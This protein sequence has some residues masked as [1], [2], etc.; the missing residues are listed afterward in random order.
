MLI[1]LGNIGLAILPVLA[2]LLLFH[3]TGP[4]LSW[5]KL[6]K[7]LL[8]GY[9]IVIPAF[10]IE[11]GL[12][13]LLERDSVHLPEMARL[14]LYSFVIAAIT[15]EFFKLLIIR[16]IRSKND[17]AR[18]M[19]VASFMA[20][21]GFALFENLKYIFGP[22]SILLLR[23]ITA[24]PLHGICAAFIGYSFAIK[25]EKKRSAPVAGFLIAVIF[26]G[27]YDL[28]LM[29]ETVYSYIVL[30]LLLIMYAII[31][32]LYSLSV[33]RRDYFR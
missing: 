17:S 9:L 29:T 24:V 20:G 28:L 4:K 6:Y 16:Q 15:E 31:R 12:V 8:L 22:T 5:P 13:N 26:H 30:I 33:Q 19:L 2:L 18:E 3:K 27:L 25:T 7:P 21:V 10:I 1:L 14:L 23:S 11:I 32:I